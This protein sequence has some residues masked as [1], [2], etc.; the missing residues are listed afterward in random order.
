MGI[1]PIAGL[2]HLT[3][4]SLAVVQSEPDESSP[5]QCERSYCRAASAHRPA[6]GLRFQPLLNLER[7]NIAWLL[8]GR[9]RVFILKAPWPYAKGLLKN[10]LMFQRAIA[11]AIQKLYVQTMHFQCKALALSIPDL[12]FSVLPNMFGSRDFQSLPEPMN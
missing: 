4:L 7:L 9:N 11:L 6:V 5:S 12:S 2:S 1:A 3:L 8:A 10:K